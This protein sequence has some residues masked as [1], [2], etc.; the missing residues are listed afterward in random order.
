MRAWPSVDNRPWRA[1][2]SPAECMAA[3]MKDS[4]LDSSGHRGKV[5]DARTTTAK[6]ADQAA[7]NFEYDDNEW[8]IG[9]GDLIIDLDAD[10]E[11][12]NEITPTTTTS[13]NP[14]VVL[15]GTTTTTTASG[16]AGTSIIGGPTNMASTGASGPGNSGPS[17]KTTAGK[18]AIEHS[19][20]VDKGLKMKIKRTKPGTKTSE[21]KHEIV[22]SNELNGNAEL[23]G[24]GPAGPGTSSAA[25]GV[26]AGGTAGGNN[27][28]NDSKGGNSV[29]KHTGSTSNTPN[30]GANS[31]QNQTTVLNSSV[32][33]TNSATS[34]VNSTNNKRGSSSH[35]RDKASRDKHG[36]NTTASDKPQ[37]SPKPA[38][39]SSTGSS[40]SGLTGATVPSATNSAASGT[41]NNS[42]SASLTTS[43]V[44]ASANPTVGNPV[45]LDPV[46]GIVRTTTP[47]QQSTPRSVFSPSTGPGPPGSSSVGSVTVGNSSTAT[48]S[49]GSVAI[50]S[51]QINK[52]PQVV[53]VPA[54]I[55][56]QSSSGSGEDRSTSPP[57]TKKIKPSTDPKVSHPPFLIFLTHA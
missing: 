16:I 35:R 1:T 4:S 33:G 17:S 15:V 43:T 27:S 7:S 52:I 55:A 22:K 25:G 40:T 46:N 12:T 10:I 53:V 38:S 42:A 6:T 29:G 39:A 11:K 32:S 28:G 47:S 13:N 36:N 19:A 45:S 2:S 48:S 56:P 57:P 44:S 9:I 18:M 24:A 21:A 31:G 54:T 26:N 41:S 49:S 30:S 3:P 50:K 5:V 34:G 20:T 14:T 51:E 23:A 37:T 8:D